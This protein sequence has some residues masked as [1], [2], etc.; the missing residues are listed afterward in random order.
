L[1]QKVDSGRAG[2]A[3]RPRNPEVSRIASRSTVTQSDSISH[4]LNGPND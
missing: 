3:A 2:V 1:E 4:G